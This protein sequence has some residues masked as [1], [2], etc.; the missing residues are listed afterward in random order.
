MGLVISILPLCQTSC[1]RFRDYFKCGGQF[2]FIFSRT[3]LDLLIITRSNKICLSFFVEFLR[4]CNDY[5]WSILKTFKRLTLCKYDIL[6][7]QQRL[8]LCKYDILVYQQRLTRDD[9]GR[10]TRSLSPNEF[11][12][13]MG[14]QRD[15]VLFL[16]TR[17]V[18]SYCFCSSWADVHFMF[19]LFCIDFFLRVLCDMFSEG[20]LGRIYLGKSTWGNMVSFYFIL[21]ILLH[22][23]RTHFG[24][25][26]YYIFSILSVSSDVLKRRIICGK[27][28]AQIVC[29]IQILVC[30]VLKLV[31]SMDQNEYGFMNVFGQNLNNKNDEFSDG[32]E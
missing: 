32:F 3:L 9:N 29:I 2:R 17:T 7:Y 31:L 15:Y 20:D 26:A 13:N 10:F 1:L 23:P 28:F 19:C 5:S 21:C 18:T 24:I 16:T 22:K 11:F 6:V 12:T 4:F 30:H 25:F 8:T 27:L 14:V